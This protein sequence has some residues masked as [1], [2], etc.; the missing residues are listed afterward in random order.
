[1]EAGLEDAQSNDTMRELLQKP[2]NVELVA[3][4]TLGGL[5]DLRDSL[6]DLEEVLIGDSQ[7]T[8]GRPKANVGHRTVVELVLLLS[9]QL[10]LNVE[11]LGVL[12]ENVS[13][14]QGDVLSSAFW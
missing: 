14:H 13:V 6:G 5:K 12:R 11:I 9:G 1:M 7:S 4:G 8:C 2:L 3:I 10:K